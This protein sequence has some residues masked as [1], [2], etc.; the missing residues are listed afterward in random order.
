M[1]SIHRRLT[2]TLFRLH[3]NT[4]H[5]FTKSAQD[6]AYAKYSSLG[7]FQRWSAVS[8]WPSACQQQRR[9]VLELSARLCSCFLPLSTTV[10]H[11]ARATVGG[12][13]CKAKAI[14]ISRKAASKGMQSSIIQKQLQKQSMQHVQ[15]KLTIDSPQLIIGYHDALPG[16]MYVPQDAGHI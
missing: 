14:R 8:C 5:N 13:R 16:N 1:G 11:N 3:A 15:D 4:C 10:W 9:H 7:A 2:A 6:G 12:C